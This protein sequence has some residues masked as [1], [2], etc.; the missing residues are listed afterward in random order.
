VWRGIR[1]DGRLQLLAGWAGFGLVFFS[2]WTNK[3]PGYVLPLMPAIFALIGVRLSEATT[4]ARWLP[5]SAGLVGLIP[6]VA[7]VLPKALDVGLSRVDPKAL[8]WGYVAV[9]F[10]LSFCVWGCQRWRGTGWASALVAGLCV[11]GVVY[12]KITVLPVLDREV[13]AR[14]VWLSVKDRGDVCVEDVGRKLMYGLNYYTVMPLRDCVEGDQA[15][16]LGSPNLP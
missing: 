12:M 15:Y 13:S 3:L 11:G 7:A 1:P 10:V 5:V 8:P 16:R 14:G 9:G 6:L 4:K 2:V